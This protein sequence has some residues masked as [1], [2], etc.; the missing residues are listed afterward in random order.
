MECVI[1]EVKS[2]AL[3]HAVRIECQIQVSSRAVECPKT[4]LSRDITAKLSKPACSLMWSVMN[5]QVVMINTAAE[6][7]TA[8][9]INVKYV[10]H[11]S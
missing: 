1:T 9:I 6:D 5:L 4:E 7:V 8:C 3:V 11:Q 2:Y 10:V